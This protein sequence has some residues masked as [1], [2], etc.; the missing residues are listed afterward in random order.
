MPHRSPLRAGC[1]V[2]VLV[3]LTGCRSYR[4]AT[5]SSVELGDDVRIQTIDGRAVEF[6]VGFLDRDAIGGTGVHVP[7]ERI[8]SVAVYQRT[9]AGTVLNVMS[10]AKEIV[11]FT[12]VGVTAIVV[13]LAL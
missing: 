2:L 13:V 8:E 11:F 12:A 5:L 10:H 6:E 3:A 9:T 1:L 4:P 7:V